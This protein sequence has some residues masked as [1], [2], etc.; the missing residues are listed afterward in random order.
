MLLLIMVMTTMTIRIMIIKT[1]VNPVNPN[2][3]DS[4]GG[5][6]Q[7]TTVL[8]HS[9]KDDLPNQLDHG[10]RLWGFRVSSFCFRLQ[11]Y[12]YMYLYMPKSLNLK[13]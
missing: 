1:G 5:T 8:S 7:R 9:G 11:C 6:Q 4:L 12:M 3:I 10:L 13:P 2:P